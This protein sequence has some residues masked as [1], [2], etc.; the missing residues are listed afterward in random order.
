MLHRDQ[1]QTTN[2]VSGS[3]IPKNL[4]ISSHMKP[5]SSGR[6]M[7]SDGYMSLVPLTLCPTRRV[8]AG[9]G[10]ELSLYDSGFLLPSSKYSYGT[11]SS[12]LILFCSFIL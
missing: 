5:A 1:L 7:S 12:Y 3:Q 2:V 10:P 11:G 6:R 4:A 8:T 9:Q